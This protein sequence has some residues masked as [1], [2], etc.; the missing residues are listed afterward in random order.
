MPVLGKNKRH[1]SRSSETQESEGSKSI[2][3][4]DDDDDVLLYM[5]TPATHCDP[6]HALSLSLSETRWSVL[7]GPVG[8]DAAWNRLGDE[9]FI[10][11]ELR[12]PRSGRPEHP[13]RW[14]PGVQGVRFRSLEGPGGRR[15]RGRLHHPG[16]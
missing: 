15:T 7:R 1:E 2:G 16:E 11:H 14:K 5:I 3:T 13:G 4:P 6:D 9:I 10:R 8:R 12:P